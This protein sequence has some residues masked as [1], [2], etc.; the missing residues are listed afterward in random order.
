V[1]AKTK[2][3]F[4]RGMGN[5]RQKA[6]VCSTSGPDLNQNV[7]TFWQAISLAATSQSVFHR[8]EPISQ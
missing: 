5:R 1:P 4:G 8:I 7:E 6:I 3:A 2:I